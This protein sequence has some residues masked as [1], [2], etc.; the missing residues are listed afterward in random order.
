MIMACQISP[1]FPIITISQDK[2]LPLLLLWECRLEYSVLLGSTLSV[3]NATAL[4][5]EV[6][7]Y[8]NPREIYFVLKS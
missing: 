2:T 6:N 7:R 3:F 8:H 1:H 5:H 4:P